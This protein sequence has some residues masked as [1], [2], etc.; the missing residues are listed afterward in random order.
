MVADSIEREIVITAPAD[1]VWDVLTQA[2]FLGAW[3]GSGGPAEVDLRPG[4]RMV[5][6]HGARHPPGPD[7][8]G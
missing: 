2:E 7:R 5:F 8:A 4:G 3:F 6:D 1:R